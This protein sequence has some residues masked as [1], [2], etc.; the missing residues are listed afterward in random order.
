MSRNSS[1]STFAEPGLSVGQAVYLR[2]PLA[3][4]GLARGALGA[5]VMVLTRPRL[6]YEVEF[7][8]DDGK[9]RALTT[10]RPEQ[11]SA[12]RRLQPD[13]ATVVK[14]FLAVLRWQ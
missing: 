2:E 12:P 8:D 1:R 4:L 9:T 10:L 3:R 14:M 13:R 6:A 5:V 11:I 7:V